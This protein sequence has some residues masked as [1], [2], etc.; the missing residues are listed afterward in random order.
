MRVSQTPRLLSILHF[1][2]RPFSIEGYI[3]SKNKAAGIHL[4]H[5]NDP[6]VFSTIEAQASPFS[7]RGFE[8]WRHA[9][10]VCGA[11][12]CCFSFYQPFFSTTSQLFLSLKRGLRPV[13]DSK[14]SSLS[15][16]HGARSAVFLYAEKRPRR[17]A[18][19]LIHDLHRHRFC[20]SSPRRP[21]QVGRTSAR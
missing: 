12:R 15:H 11:H 19:S 5:R 8:P 1:I 20:S 14:A 2:R 7:L 21:S 17:A 10:R 13:T 18:L 3:A 4:L 9:W 6:Q 16:L